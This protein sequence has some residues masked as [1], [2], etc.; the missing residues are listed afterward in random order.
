MRR[1]SVVADSAAR[2]V[3]TSPT[4][5]AMAY[6]RA[7]RIHY[8]ATTRNKYDAESVLG[9]V[10]P[11]LTNAEKREVGMRT[12]VQHSADQYDKIRVNIIRNIFR[13]PTSK[14]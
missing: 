12:V 8:P 5:T 4:P 13:S 3:T 1:W 2:T 6:R 7:G 10:R 11:V 14:L 9:R